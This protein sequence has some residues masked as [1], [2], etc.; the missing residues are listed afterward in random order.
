MSQI[1]KE[2]DNLFPFPKDTCIGNSELD[3][4][5]NEVAQEI[6]SGSIAYSESPRRAYKTKEVRVKVA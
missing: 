2:E 6:V 4:G 1:H 5:L 3:C